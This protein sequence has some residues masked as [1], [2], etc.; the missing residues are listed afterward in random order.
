MDLPGQ[1]S[2]ERTLVASPGWTTQCFMIRRSFRDQ[3]APDLAHGSLSL[4][5]LGQPFAADDKR[6][7]LSE[8]A[9]DALANNRKVTQAAA[10]A[11]LEEKFQD[12]M[13]GLLVGH[14]L[15]RDTPEASILGEVVGNLVKLLGSEHPD[16]QA[17]M[18]A[19]S[20]P[21]APSSVTQMPMLR[22]S[23]DAI[24]ARTL[25]QP[26][27]V[28]AQSPAALVSARVLPSSPW[29]TW[30]AA[31]APTARQADAKMAVLR[32]FLNRPAEPSLEGAAQYRDFSFSAPSPPSLDT[33]DR[34]ELARSLGVPSS[35]L[36]DMLAKLDK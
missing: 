26:S 15:L 17:L 2:R 14:L 35:V 24:V 11:L 10:R 16:V 29:L 5:Q 21:D 4:S 20:S 31:D 12:P 19:A 36:D 9:S 6:T 3:V 1:P 13:L 27:L 7:R 25:T 30:E 8:A 22:P 23:W 32:G 33:E 34:A 28:P 18:L